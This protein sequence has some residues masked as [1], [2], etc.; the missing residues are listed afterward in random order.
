MG[1]GRTFTA[2]IKEI[3]S[4]KK[5][6]IVDLG[7]MDYLPAIE[8]M[9]DVRN[10][11][12]HGADDTLLIVEHN[13][14]ITIGTDDDENSILDKTYIKKHKI[15]V[16]RT[17]RA[18]GAVA[19]NNGQIVC[20]PVL[21]VETMPVDL[22]PGILATMTDALVDFNIRPRKG[23]EPGIWV[24]DYKIGF[25]GMKI[26]KG[27]SIHGFAMN[28]SNNLDIFRTI[29][30]CGKEDEKI[31]NLTLS[32]KTI[33]PLDKMKKSIISKFAMRFNYLPDRF[34]VKEGSA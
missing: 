19:H 7:T 3:Q 30:T 15:P 18:G 23:K 29:K 12:E 27:V 17:E 10:E 32:I 5:L 9:H 21:K 13:P 2:Y 34:V 26:H 24:S 8:I 1:S 6:R 11:V 22:I 25:V 33:I 4:M 28:I 20:Y 16:I 14:V 31:T